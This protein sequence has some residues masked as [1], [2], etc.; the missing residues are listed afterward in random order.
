VD[1]HRKSSTPLLASTGRGLDYTRA[2][3]ESIKTAS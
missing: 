1:Y 3:H 2:T